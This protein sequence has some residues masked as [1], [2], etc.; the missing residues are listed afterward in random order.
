MIQNCKYRI[1]LIIALAV[2]FENCKNDSKLNE[3]TT[4]RNWITFDLYDYSQQIHTTDTIFS[5]ND[6]SGKCIYNDSLVLN[7]KINKNEFK[8]FNDTLHLANLHKL[9]AIILKSN[10]KNIDTIWVLYQHKDFNDYRDWFAD[11]VYYSSKWG[12]IIKKSGRF[13][14]YV[15]RERI[16][17][18][19]KEQTCLFDNYV[20][21]ILFDQFKFEQTSCCFGEIEVNDLSNVKVTTKKLDLD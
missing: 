5:M 16:I 9:N 20:K 3:T 21:L 10:F 4:I 6:T 12:V 15:S 11:I 14:S 19:G 17:E 18:S 2:L 8:A 13:V 7:I 1:V